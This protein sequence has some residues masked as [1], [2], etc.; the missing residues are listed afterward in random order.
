[1]DKSE[2]PPMKSEPIP[3]NNDEIVKII[4]GRTFRRIVNNPK[5]DVLVLF[6]D[7]VEQESI[8]ALALFEELAES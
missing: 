2:P 5:I 7:P 4:V 1:M 3:E 6:Y 8:D